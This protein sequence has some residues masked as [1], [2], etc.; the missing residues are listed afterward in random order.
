[1]AANQ[2][3]AANHTKSLEQLETEIR[4]IDSQMCEEW[5]E[6]GV[7]LDE[8]KKGKFKEC[9][10]KSWHDYCK[11]G[12]LELCGSRQHA[13]SHIAAAKVLPALKQSKLLPLDR[14]QFSLKF[15]EQF[16]K[17][18]TV[19]DIKRVANKLATH[20]KKTPSAKLTA[21]LAK[22]FIDEDRGEPRKKQ[23][24]QRA[25]I[26]ATPTAGEFILSKS[27][28]I[29]QLTVSLE[30]WAPEMWDEVP[31]EALRGFVDELAHL[32]EFLEQ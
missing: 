6:I 9:G 5:Y 29:G 14:Q 20:I 21:P 18:E 28:E 13:E 4:Q 22:Q 26:G 1:M 10:A 11:S 8:I 3:Q 15:S 7:R 27:E 31:K 12:R 2:L 25:K 32:I 16:S 24:R 17:L 23:E 30:Q 19:T